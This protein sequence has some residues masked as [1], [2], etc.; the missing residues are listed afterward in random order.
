MTVD[1]EQG[2]FQDAFDYTW[3]ALNGHFILMELDEVQEEYSRFYSYILLNGKKCCLKTAYNREKGAFEILGTYRLL[4]NNWLDRDVLQLKPGDKI[5]PL[6]LTE[7]GEFVNGESFVLEQEPFL[8]DK[9]L[10]EGK[11]AF[12]FRFDTPHKDVVDSEGA[13]FVIEGGNLTK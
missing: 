6:F 1:W 7:K 5:T 13:Y 10:P 2:I 9:P 3:P 8:E 11:Y 4:E 12:N